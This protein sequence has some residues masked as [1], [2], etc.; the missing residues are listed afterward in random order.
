MTYHLKIYSWLVGLAL[1][2][3][4]L[5]PI[6][7]NTTKF[8]QK[9]AVSHISDEIHNY[10][11][12]IILE[13]KAPGI[14][15]AIISSEGIIAIGSAGVR[16]E[17]SDVS[18]TCND[19][20][21]LGS[22]TKTMTSVMLATLVA[23]GKLSWD[24]KLTEVIPELKETIHSD[25]HNITLWQLL[26]HRAGLSKNATDWKAHTDK[27]IIERRLAILKDNLTLDASTDIGEFHYSNLGYMIAACM[28][29]KVTGICWESLMEKRLFDPLGMSS[30]D[31]GRLNTHNQINQPWGHSWGYSLFG[32]NWEP[33]QSDNSESLGPAG[34]VNCNIED[35]AKFLS[36]FLSNEN[37]VIDSKHLNKLI[38][39][40]GMYAGGWVVLKEEEQPWAKGNVLAHAG[41]NGLWYTS[42]MV[43]P[44]LNRAYIVATNSREFGS[45]EFV[46]RDMINKLVRIDLNIGKAP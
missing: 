30:A 36:L 32:N 46:C 45:T 20:I 26:T 31:F 7:S 41:S 34:R 38:T 5:N 24:M 33:D 1:L 40:I 6:N 44:K 10:L 21:H 23:E 35:W 2:V 19:N 9:L 16:K 43:A 25:Y 15:A 8:A 17:G 29:E 12:D 14:V 27:K 18:F 39:P 4:L 28:A 42:V 22:C 11:A 37:P 13:G 3:I